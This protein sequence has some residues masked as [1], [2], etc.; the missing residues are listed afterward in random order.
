MCFVDEGWG[1][2]LNERRVNKEL[3]ELGRMG[4][5]EAIYELQTAR[6]CM[7]WEPANRHFAALYKE[8]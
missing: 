6:R 8:H 2:G 7:N 1:A 3:Y 4:G 5:S